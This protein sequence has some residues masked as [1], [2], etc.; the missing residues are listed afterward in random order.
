MRFSIPAAAALLVLSAVPSAGQ[1]DVRAAAVRAREA[2]HAR[3]PWARAV[4]AAGAVAGTAYLAH[5]SRDV[6]GWCGGVRSPFATLDHCRGLA[7]GGGRVDDAAGRFLPHGSRVYVGGRQW[8]VLKCGP[9]GV[10]NCVDGA[11][12]A[13]LRRGPWPGGGAASAALAAGAFAAA[14]GLAEL[15]DGGG[16]PSDRPP[17]WLKIAAAGVAAVAAGAAVHSAREGQAD[18]SSA[19]RGAFAGAMTAMAAWG[20]VHRIGW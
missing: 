20:V 9:G 8:F 13:A 4:A 12:H 16:V 5:R 19:G 11:E 17:A 1:S 10:L 3:F 15:G 6:E 7:P 18:G 2:S 14:W